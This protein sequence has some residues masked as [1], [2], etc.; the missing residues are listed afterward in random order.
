MSATWTADWKTPT[1]VINNAYI[2]FIPQVSYSCEF[3]FFFQGLTDDITA[4]TSSVAHLY[5]HLTKPILDLVLITISLY[6][7]GKG[8]G[9]STVPG[10]EKTINCGISC[11]IVL[12]SV[13]FR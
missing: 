11:V 2:V 12:K 5:S 6:N 7:I 10:L 9:G 8:M 1:I 3:F 4:F 13:S